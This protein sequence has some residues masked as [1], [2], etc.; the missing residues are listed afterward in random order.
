[1]TE[2]IN[3][4]AFFRQIRYLNL[5]RK[6]YNFADYRKEVEFEKT[7]YM[8]GFVLFN[9]AKNEY[10]LETDTGEVYVAYSVRSLGVTIDHLE[11]YCGPEYANQHYIVFHAVVKERK[12]IFGRR[13]R[14]PTYDIFMIET[15]APLWNSR[16]D[17]LKDI[18]RLTHLENLGGR[19]ND[20]TG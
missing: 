18:E 3:H 20:L 1:M 10:L 16:V 19:I 4:T 8:S 2:E 5:A 14:D 12:G 9:L 7:T 6:G 17:N 13:K 15:K 11:Q